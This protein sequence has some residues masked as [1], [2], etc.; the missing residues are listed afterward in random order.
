MKIQHIH[1]RWNYIYNQIKHTL[2]LEHEVNA[3]LCMENTT[4]HVHKDLMLN[5][6]LSIIYNMSLWDSVLN[7]Q[8]LLLTR[9]FSRFGLG[10]E[11]WC[12]TPLS[13]IF[14]LCHGS[15]FYWWRKPEYLENTTELAASHLCLNILCPILPVDCPIWISPSVFSNIY[16]QGAYNLMGYVYQLIVIPT[17]LAA[18]HWW[19]WSHNVVSSTPGHEWDSNSHN[20]IG[21]IIKI[22]C[23]IQ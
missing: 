9:K 6:N 4:L 23:N 18:S 11:L 12:L 17:E 20:F 15:Q 14:Q 16:S 10:L 19:T 1:I 5:N 2:P 7:K 3:Y 8:R 13:T 22:W 21:M